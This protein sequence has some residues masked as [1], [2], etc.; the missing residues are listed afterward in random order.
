VI[1]AAII[2]GSSERTQYGGGACGLRQKAL[3]EKTVLCT[4]AG[5]LTPDGGCLRPNEYFFREY[6]QPGVLMEDSWAA[7]IDEPRLLKNQLGR[8]WNREWMWC[9]CFYLHNR[10]RSWRNTEGGFSERVREAFTFLKRR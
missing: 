9:R 2:T 4:K 3:G 5:Y 1:D 10:R 8:S 7:D 6:I